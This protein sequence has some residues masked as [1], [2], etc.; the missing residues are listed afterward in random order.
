VDLSS[1]EDI[2]TNFPT[3]GAAACGTSKDV[4]APAQPF[5][6]LATFKSKIKTKRRDLLCAGRESI[7]FIR[8]KIKKSDGCSRRFYSFKWRII[9]CRLSQSGRVAATTAG[10]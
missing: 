3:R 7:G 1:D 6:F 4:V 10:L 2:T 9:E 8:L 5:D